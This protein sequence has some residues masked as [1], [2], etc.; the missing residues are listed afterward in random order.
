MSNTPA[1]P[2]LY[3][4]HEKALNEFH[5][6]SRLLDKTKALYTKEAEDL[7]T[8]DKRLMEIELAIIQGNNLVLEKLFTYHKVKRKRLSS[9]NS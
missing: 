5:E 8:P 2:K 6:A 3:E 1:K 4:E 7:N 9:H